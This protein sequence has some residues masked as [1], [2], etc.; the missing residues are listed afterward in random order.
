MGITVPK[1]VH[2]AFRDV[3][4]EFGPRKLASMM[5]TPLG[6]LYN[7]CNTENE[8]GHHKPTLRDA[9][10]V[11]LLTGDKRI[12]KAFSSAVGGVHHDLPNLS[13]LSTDALMLHILE[14]EQQ[15]GDFYRVMK[16]SL[17]KDNEIS[18]AEFVSI[19][20]EAH[21]WISA[22]LEALVRLEEMSRG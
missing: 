22:I 21:Q 4:F 18:P 3:V 5:S 16:S 1:D 9:V 19:E 11:T 17:E 12:A 2:Q 14:I 10:L 7:K 8:D 20:R 13:D 15:G 6:T